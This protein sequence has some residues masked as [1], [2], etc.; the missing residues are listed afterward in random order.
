MNTFAEAPELLDGHV[1]EASDNPYATPAE[2]RKGRYEWPLWRR[3]LYACAGIAIVYLL[4]GA[5][6][7]WQAFQKTIIHHDAPMIE[8]VKSFFTEWRNPKL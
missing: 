3:I 6:A 7:S 4:C 5:V 8:Q 1:T 2:R